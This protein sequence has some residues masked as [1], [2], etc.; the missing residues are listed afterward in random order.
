MSTMLTIILYIVG[1]AGAGIAIFYAS[2]MLFGF[3]AEHCSVLSALFKVCLFGL[4]CVNI[5]ALGNGEVPNHLSQEYA[6]GAFIAIAII[7]LIIHIFAPRKDLIWHCSSKSEERHYKTTYYVDLNSG[8][9]GSRGGGSSTII[10]ECFELSYSSKKFKDSSKKFMWS[11]GISGKYS[12]LLYNGWGKY[13][14]MHLPDWYITKI[15]M[16]IFPFTSAL[17]LLFIG[18]AC[19]YSPVLIL[20]LLLPSLWYIFYNKRL[21]FALA[22]GDIHGCNKPTY[23]IS[24]AV[25]AVVCFFNLLYFG[26]FGI[27]YWEM[28]GIYILFSLISTIYFYTAKR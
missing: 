23:W 21:Y 7:C 28:L 22:D 12:I 24:I 13:G 4:F 20:P 1:I 27:E 9:F 5:Y 3:I 18:K 2:V 11:N 6:I 16:F 10:Y 17:W 19:K 15:S 26:N 8:D 14:I 25:D